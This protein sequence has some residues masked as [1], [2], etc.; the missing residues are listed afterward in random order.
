MMGPAASQG[1][2]GNFMRAPSDA[3]GNLIMNRAIL[4]TI[5]LRVNLPLC[6]PWHCKC[7]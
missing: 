2:L 7:E 6:K 3:W 5:H 1:V 4:Q